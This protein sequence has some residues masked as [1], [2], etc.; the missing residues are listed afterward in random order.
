MSTEVGS[1]FIFFEQGIKVL[2]QTLCGPMFRHR[3]HRIV[4]CHQQKVCLG[5]SQSLLQP[6]QLPVSSQQIH[7]A[8]GLL[9]CVVE[10]VAAQHYSVEHDYGQ[11]LP[12]VGNVEVQLVIIRR[13]FP[14]ITKKVNKVQLNVVTV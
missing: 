10:R 4:A 11:S 6:D 14:E 12:C 8:S 7:R 5:Q 13:E 3:P 9:I 1:G 2:Q